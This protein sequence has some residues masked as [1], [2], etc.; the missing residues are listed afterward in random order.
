MTVRREHLL[1]GTKQK[2]GKFAAANK[3]GSSY[4]VFFIGKSTLYHTWHGRCGE[5]WK[6]L[7]AHDQFAKQQLL[8]EGTIC[9]C[10]QKMFAG[11]NAALAAS[12]KG[13]STLY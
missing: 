3:D 4:R 2:I 10:K 13:L 1:T 8:S 12:P 6:I 9:C 7:L 5:Y 11:L